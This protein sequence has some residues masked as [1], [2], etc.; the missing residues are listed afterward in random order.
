MRL[1]LLLAVPL[2]ASG[3]VWA[4]PP[5]QAA[6]SVT[7]TYTGSAQ[8]WTVPVGVT[9]VDLTV[10]GAGGGGSVSPGGSGARVEVT[11]LSVTPG[12]SFTFRIGGGGQ[13]SVREVTSAPLLLAQK[14]VPS[15]AGQNDYYEPG[16][17]GGSTIV[18]YSA[19][20]DFFVV[21]GGGGGSVGAV[22][23]NQFGPALLALTGGAG[24]RTGGDGDVD[25][26]RQFS[27]ACGG[28]TDR[29]S[30]G[31]TSAGIGGLA[32]TYAGSGGNW[33]NGFGGWSGADGVTDRVTGGQPGGPGGAY[34]DPSQNYNEHGGSGG[35]GYGGGSGGS[36][37]SGGA[38]GGGGGGSSYASVPATFTTGGGGAGGVAFTDLGTPTPRGIWDEYGATNPGSNGSVVITYTFNAPTLTSITP[39]VGARAGG[40]T[41]TLTGTGFRA[42]AT[43]TIGGV[44]AP[45]TAISPDGT[46]ITATTPAGG[47]ASANVVVTNSDAQSAT[48]AGGF[49]YSPPTIS[50]IN[51]T[52]GPTAGGTTVTLSGT[53]FIAPVTVT[54]GGA[55]AT[56]VTV[57]D[58]TSVSFDTPAGSAGSALVVLTSVGQTASTTYTYITPA[59]TVS[60]ISPSSG[61]RSGG[62]NVTITGT[63]FQSGATVTIGGASATSVTV[64]DDTQI[65]AVTPV[66]GSAAANVVVTNV[67]AQSATLAGGF[68]YDPPTITSL[69]SN[70]GTTAGGQP[71]TV[72]GTG[73][74]AP[75]TITVGGTSASNVTVL[76]DTSVSFDTPAGAAGAAS[77]VLTSVGQT[78]ST[79]YTYVNPPPAITSFTPS[80]GSKAGDDTIVI[81]GSGFLSGA[82]VSIGG[83]NASSV[84]VDSSTQITAVTPPGTS[85][86][87]AVMVTNTDAQ[88]VTAGSTYAYVNPSIS[89]LSPSSGTTSGGTTVT[90]TGAGLAGASGVTIGGNAAAI[91]SN[92]GTQIIITTPVGGLPGPESLVVTVAGNTAT[93][94]YTYTAPAP[95]IT[96]INPTTGPTGGGTTVTITGTDLGGVTSVTF[97][98]TPATIVSQSATQIVV[99]SP[100]G[101]AGVAQIVVADGAQTASANFTYTTPTPPTPPT[102]ARKPGPPRDV[103]G[104]AGDKSVTV[105]WV[106]PSSAGSFA[107]TTYEVQDS[108]GQHTCLYAVS[109]GDPL[110]CEISGLANGTEYTFRVR[111]LSGAGWSDWSAASEPLTPQSPVVASMLITG[112]RDDGRPRRIIVDGVTEHMV[113]SVV[114][115]WLHLPGQRGFAQ[116]SARVTIGDDGYF[117][118]GRN[119]N[120]RVRLYFSDGLIRSNVIRIPARK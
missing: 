56:N 106:A 97:A 104:V 2:M 54:V 19:D 30:K 21:A 10:K 59:P 118:W 1:P 115:P 25:E 12:E 14:A 85:A 34:S 72:T 53:G 39:A 16:A 64:V 82:T 62:T 119:V 4:A 91:V 78:A 99:L 67:D 31:G 44:S 66:G 79:T 60:S 23:W 71:V 77:V 88:S 114:A 103:T 107:I 87:A 70:S 68:A 29:C 41:V 81:T 17:G 32:G 27:A 100:A 45:V 89:S 73:F 9:S 58:D 109:A 92:S 3:L 120:K 105:S 63:G 93:S 90:I 52:S 8:T 110:E 113:G 36:S 51:P 37:R 20:G 47:S 101:V 74:I 69:S 7:F 46:Q 35:A 86:T 49:S 40:E 22:V 102:P 61:A 57:L 15:V 18:E 5:A 50:S 84:S 76:D 96:S 55:S 13:G 38:W 65:T 80:S 95:A 112:G 33:P 108:V 117:T 11:R 6:T 116:G 98:L 28:D 48:L 83:A 94:T 111:A 75:V 43:V 26:D 24:G 42:G